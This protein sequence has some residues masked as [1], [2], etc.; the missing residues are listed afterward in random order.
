MPDFRE[1]LDVGRE[2][3]NGENF[4]MPPHTYTKDQVLRIYGDARNK[5]E[6][7]WESN[8]NLIG[9]DAYDGFLKWFLDELEREKDKQQQP[10]YR[11]AIIAIEGRQWCDYD[12][13]YRQSKITVNEENIEDVKR[14][15]KEPVEIGDKIPSIHFYL[16]TAIRVRN[17]TFTR[18]SFS[19]GEDMWDELA[20][21]L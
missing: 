19:A 20:D 1:G 21:L 4:E 10:L 2:V 9:E 6:I 17:P 18:L 13:Q 16:Y 8:V 7:Y 5:E 11:H 15:S 14:I 12:V 3:S